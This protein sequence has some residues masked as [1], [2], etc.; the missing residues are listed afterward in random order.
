MDRTVT[1]RGALADWLHSLATIYIVPGMPVEAGD[2]FA[3]ERQAAA[4]FC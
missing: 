4:T 1:L 3:P 2:L